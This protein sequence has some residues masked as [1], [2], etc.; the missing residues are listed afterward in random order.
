MEEAVPM[1]KTAIVVVVSAPTSDTRTET[2][3][4]RTGRAF[5]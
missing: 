1:K 4:P 2:R 3:K 5:S